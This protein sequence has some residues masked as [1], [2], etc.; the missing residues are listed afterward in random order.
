MSHP[1]PTRPLPHENRPSHWPF[2]LDAAQEARAATLHADSVICDM[3]FVAP[4]GPTA[5]PP[6]LTAEVE[7]FWEASGDASLMFAECD[8]LI[9]HRAARG[10]LDA[11]R[12]GW[13]ASG[14][15]VGQCWLELASVEELIR[16]AGGAQALFDNLP[17]MRKAL[18]AADIR[19]AKR[20]G[21]HAAF[22]YSESISPIRPDL[23]IIDSMWGLG[24]RMLQLTYSTDAVGGD[25][26]APAHVGLSAFG[27]RVIRRANDLDL[28]LCVS[29]SNETTT[30]DACRVSTAPLVASHTC[31][32]ALHPHPRAKSD[33]ELRAIAQ[34]GG[35]VGVNAIPWFLSATAGATIETMLD[36]VDYICDLIGWQHVG[37]GTD[38]PL[39][40]PMSVIESAFRQWVSGPL[41]PRPDDLLFLPGLADC[42]DFPNI[43]RGLVARGYDDEQIRGILGENFLRVFEAV[44]G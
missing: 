9:A 12:E 38:W 44:V 22:L 19:E 41:G 31:A 34:T 18:C 32:A 10:Q 25:C 13:D 39:Q 33:D 23:R 11:Y 27:E 17:W 26:T 30:L 2:P 4:L 21:E 28:L 20:R 6:A 35:V 36:H 3:W 1:N 7:A 5:F 29:H 37:I 43:T 42:R 16:F 15:T 8:A 40:A 24:L 14:I